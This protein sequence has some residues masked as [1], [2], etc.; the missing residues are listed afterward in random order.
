MANLDE[1][2]KKHSLDTTPCVQNIPIEALEL[3]SGGSGDDDG[4]D[5]ILY[6]IADV[7]VVDTDT[8]I[9]LA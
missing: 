5:I 4:F 2:G 1:I 7:A 6:D 8:N 3:I 9:T